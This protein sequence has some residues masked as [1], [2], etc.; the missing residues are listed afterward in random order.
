[1]D[2]RKVKRPAYRIPRVSMENLRTGEVAVLVYD[3]GWKLADK[4]ETRR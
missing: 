3:G 1:M 2:I 4:Q